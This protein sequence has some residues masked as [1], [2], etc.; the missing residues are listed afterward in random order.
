[1]IQYKKYET[2]PN[3]LAT[4]GKHVFKNKNTKMEKFKEI[5]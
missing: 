5:E 3:A 4:N 1:M 2:T